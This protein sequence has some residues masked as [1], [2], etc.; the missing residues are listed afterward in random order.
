MATTLCH[1]F[2]FI[3]AIFCE[4]KSFLSIPGVFSFVLLLVI[5]SNAP[6]DILVLSSHMICVSK[7]RNEALEANFIETKFFNCLQSLC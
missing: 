2:V 3:S 6:R 4:R 1:S 7:W 5:I